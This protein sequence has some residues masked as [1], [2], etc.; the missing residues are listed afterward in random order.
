MSPGYYSDSATIYP[1]ADETWRSVNQSSE[2]YKQMI[3]DLSREIKNLQIQVQQLRKAN[4]TVAPSKCAQCDLRA[5]SMRAVQTLSKRLE[6]QESAKPLGNPIK[7]NLE[8]FNL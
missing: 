7:L 6:Q 5:E 4:M 1:I 3:R 2:Y 8:S